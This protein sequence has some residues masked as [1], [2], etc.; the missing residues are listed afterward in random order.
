VLQAA[1]YYYYYYYYYY[2]RRDK[3]VRGEGDPDNLMA[4]N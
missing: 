3:G 2:K 1:Y 4:G